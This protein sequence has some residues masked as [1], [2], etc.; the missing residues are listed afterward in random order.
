M[1]ESDPVLAQALVP[2]EAPPVSHGDE[3]VAKDV[4]GDGTGGV[5]G[6][7]YF[8]GTHMIGVVTCPSCSLSQF[9]ALR[10]KC[11]PRPQQCVSPSN[12]SCQK[13]QT[14]DTCTAAGCQ[15]VSSP[16]II[17]GSTNRVTHCVSLQ[18]E[19]LWVSYLCKFFLVLF[20]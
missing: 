19:K 6:A 13:H 7:N 4:Y 5:C 8:M 15:P 20:L 16:V 14:A 2:T 9:E 12:A 10:S 1:D 3:P 11:C 18:R 17:D